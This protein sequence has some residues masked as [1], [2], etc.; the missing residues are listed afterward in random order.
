MKQ[1]KRLYFVLAAIFVFAIVVTALIVINFST[2]HD[3]P[4]QEYHSKIADFEQ[5]KEQFQPYIDACQ[6]GPVTDAK[7]AKQVA[8]EIITAVYG[9]SEKPYTVAYDDSEDV[10]LVFGYKNPIA[11]G[12]VAEILIRG[13]GTILAICHGK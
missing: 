1:A 12:G 2:V 6:T 8:D 3:F 13:D 5:H 7:T 11:L 4:L 9:A 10:W